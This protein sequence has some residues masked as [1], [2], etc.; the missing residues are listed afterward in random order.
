MGWA[1]GQQSEQNQLEFLRTEFAA[2]G[3]ISTAEAP[4]E[5]AAETAPKAV[6]PAMA[7]ADGM[8]SVMKMVSDFM[9]SKHILRYYY[10]KI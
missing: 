1:F 4:T 8:E 2:C 6:T 7:T 9:I 5:A 3:K 10:L